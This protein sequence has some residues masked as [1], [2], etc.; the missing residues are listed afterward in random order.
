MISMIKK[1]VFDVTEWIRPHLLQL[2]PYS[3]AR[4]EFYGVSE[5]YIF[6]DANESPYA[7]HFNRYP[8]PKQLE[9]KN[10]LAEIK[11]TIPEHIFIGNGSDEALDVLMRT[12]CEPNLDN[13][14]TLPPTYGMY[15]VLAVIN[16]IENREVCLTEAFQPDVEAILAACDSRTKMIFLCSPNNPTGNLFSDEAIVKLLINFSGL[17]VIDEAYIDFANSE[18]WMLELGDYPNLV[19]VQTLSKAYGLAGLR[20][21]ILYA[22]AEIISF[23]DRIKPPY[24][25][26]TFS[27]QAAVKK[28]KHNT[29]PW[30]VKKIIV[31]REQLISCLESL[32]WVTKVFPS[33][34]NFI[35]IQVDDATL[36][37]RQLLEQRI[38]VRNRSNQLL[39]DSC[40][41][42][43][44]G[45]HE[46]NK[47]LMTLLKSL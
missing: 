2:K 1:E 5:D 47:Q 38:V 21:G 39:C 3:S 44:I 10:T 20:I 8:D 4:D 9:L 30:Q 17:V 11:G 13:V 14:I 25:L 40:L 15:G 37:Y 6:L 16:A 45:N 24:N 43:T 27:Q 22:S 26:N 31:E 7:N 19:V 12:F 46:E 23:L 34:A 36:R 28:L 32:S 35:L 42:I 41:R 33:D 29:I 18:S